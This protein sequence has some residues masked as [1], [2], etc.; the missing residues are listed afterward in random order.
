MHLTQFSKIKPLPEALIPSGL[1]Q[2]YPKNFNM[3]VFALSVK[4]AAILD[5]LCVNIYK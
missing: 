2:T 3:F 4:D 5:K 1:M